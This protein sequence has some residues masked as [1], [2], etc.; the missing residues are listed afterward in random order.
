[1][2][3]ITGLSVAL[4]S[5]LLLAACNT[6][7]GTSSP[8]ASGPIFSTS[9]SMGE[10]MAP[11]S[12]ESMNESTAPSS[13][14]SM[15]V[16]MTCDEAWNQLSGTSIDSISD[17]NQVTN[18]LDDTIS[19][20]GTVDEWTSAAQQAMPNVDL[21]SVQDFLQLRCSTSSMLSDTQICQEIS[22]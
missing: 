2:R 21:S 1:V 19:S 7:G 14:E 12:A 5:I 20:C 11:S 8:E 18:E 3:I 16:S 4:L 22:S 6:A 13:A 10:S 9:P 17:L 15:G